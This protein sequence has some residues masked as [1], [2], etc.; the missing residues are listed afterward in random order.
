M[1][2]LDTL[3][4]AAKRVPFLHRAYLALSGEGRVR[5]IERGWLAGMKYRQYRWSTP[6]RDLVETNW[7]DELPGV[8]VRVIKGRRRFFDVGANWGFYVL[9]AAKHRDAG[10]EVV[11]FEPHPQSAAELRSQ[12]EL[13]RVANARV[14]QAA[15]SDRAGEIDFS[16]TGSAIGQKL[17]SLNDSHR[18]ARTIRVPA[19]TL[20]EAAREFG[21]PD[22]VKIDVEGA[23][24][25][26]LAGAAAVLAQNRP[27][28]L[29]EVHGESRAGEFYDH[30]ARQ[31]YRCET[32]DGRPITDRAYHHQVICRP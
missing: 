1:A 24:N 29:V 18:G 28:L 20:D 19:M 5:G 17:A 32:A 30:M 15:L 13:N 21:P 3:K 11:A 25:L 31:G 12:I 26:V 6:Q 8:F 10:C 23:E 14:M 4:R 9:L 7:N 27:V 2:L 16:D 22:L